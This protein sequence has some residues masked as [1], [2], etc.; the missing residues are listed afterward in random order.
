MNYEEILHKLAPC[1]LDCSKCMAFREGEIKKHATE[2]KRL[3]GAFD[4][5]A[6]RFSKFMPVFSCYPSF[7]KLLDHFV[8]SDCGGCRKGEGKYPNCAVAACYREKGVDFCFQCGDFPCAKVSFDPNLKERWLDMNGK[9]RETG[10]E[11]YYEDTK[12]LPRYR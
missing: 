4:S 1:G 6:A 11:R 7:K 12:D 8:Q 3:L 5:Y 10:V 2:L 9:M